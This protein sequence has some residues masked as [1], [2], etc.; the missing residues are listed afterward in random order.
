MGYY[1][2][3]INIHNTAYTNTKK[4]VGFQRC[5]SQVFGAKGWFTISWMTVY[6]EVDHFKKQ[7]N[8]YSNEKPKQRTQI[9]V[10]QKRLSNVKL[11]SSP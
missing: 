2:G 4:N 9:C 11:T 3:N 5:E 8:Y 6:R 10:T 1:H 7:R